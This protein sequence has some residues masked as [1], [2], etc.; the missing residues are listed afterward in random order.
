MNTNAMRKSRLFVRVSDA[1]Q[2]AQ[3]Q[4]TCQRVI[5]GMGSPRFRITGTLPDADFAIEYDACQRGLIHCAL[6]L[7]QL[8]DPATGFRLGPLCAHCREP[9]LCEINGIE[10]LESCEPWLFQLT[11]RYLPEGEAGS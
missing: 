8:T 3:T 6:A 9:A 1:S 5:D 4:E 7:M 2:L 11:T 10:I